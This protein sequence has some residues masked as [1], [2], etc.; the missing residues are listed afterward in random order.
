MDTN[1]L[2]YWVPPKKRNYWIIRNMEYCGVVDFMVG[3]GWEYQREQN[4]NMVSDFNL[5]RKT[6]Q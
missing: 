2:I 6:Y 4:I 3:R 1:S 5:R